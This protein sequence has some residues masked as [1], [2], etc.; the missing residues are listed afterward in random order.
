[1]KRY[2]KN[3]QYKKYKKAYF[4][5]LTRNLWGDYDENG[6]YIPWRF[7]IWSV[8]YG[9]SSSKFTKRDGKGIISFIDKDVFEKYIKPWICMTKSQRR[10]MRE[11]DLDYSSIV[12]LALKGAKMQYE[13]YL[14]E[15]YK[16]DKKFK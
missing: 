6:A 7:I 13:I 3:Y 15:K 12:K 16:Y 10:K 5:R 9:V 14:W 2:R 8:K 1:M 4:D 11:M